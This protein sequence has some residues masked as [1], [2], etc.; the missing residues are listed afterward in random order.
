[1][2]WTLRPW[3]GGAGGWDASVTNGLEA[4]EQMTSLAADVWNFLTRGQP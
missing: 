1:M 3:R 2:T 4:G